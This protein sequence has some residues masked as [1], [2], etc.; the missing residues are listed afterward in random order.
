MAPSEEPEE[1]DGPHLS[2]LVQLLVFSRLA[3]RKTIIIQYVIC[4]SRCLSWAPKDKN[5]F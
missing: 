5:Q 1:W 2:W 4:K 3:Q